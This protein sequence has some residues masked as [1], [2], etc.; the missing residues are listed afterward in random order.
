M[1]IATLTPATAVPSAVSLRAE[2]VAV[3]DPATVDAVLAGVARLLHEAT[4]TALPDIKDRYGWAY[5]HAWEHGR[6]RFAEQLT[7]AV[8]APAVRIPAQRAA[9]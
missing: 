8:P 2:L 7:A 5:G 4:G 3:Y 9:A 6:T 1:S